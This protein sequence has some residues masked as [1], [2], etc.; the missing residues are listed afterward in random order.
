MDSD[1]STDGDSPIYSSTSDLTGGSASATVS[2]LDKNQATISETATITFN[3]STASNSIAFANLSGKN[4]LERYTTTTYDL[5]INN[6][7]DLSNTA[8]TITTNAGTLTSSTG[9]GTITFTTPI[10]KDNNSGRTITAT[11]L[12]TR[13]ATVTGTGYTSEGVSS[14]SNIT[15][16]FTYPSFYIFTSSTSNPPSRAD[17]VDSFDFDSANVTEL[18]NQLKVI[19]QQINNPDGVPKCWWFAVRSAASQ[20]TTFKT[21]SDASLLVGVTPTETTV[22][23]EPDVAPVGYNSEEY[24]LYGITLNPGN[25]YVQ[26]S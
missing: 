7:S 13:P 19:D 21:G 15:V 12:F 26:I 11:T 2:F 18:S 23:L 22:D 17:I 20:P 5:T 6:I 3:W 24:K 16:T 8:T 1:F 25:T 10:H 9:D 4:F 14:D